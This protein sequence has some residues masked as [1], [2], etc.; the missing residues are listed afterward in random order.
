MAN[1]S[2]TISTKPPEQTA[3]NFA[4]LRE[5]GIAYIEKYAH[6]LWTDY[7]T[8]DPGIT[9]LEHLCYAITDLSLRTSL[10][11]SDL[12]T[13]S[14]GNEAAM[15]KSFLTAGKVLPTCPV[16]E[17]DYRKLFIDI[18]G[19]R[20][21]WL[22][23]AN[24]SVFVNCRE[25]DTARRLSY[26]APQPL[27]ANFLSFELKGLYTILVDYDQAYINQSIKDKGGDSLTQAQQETIQIQLHNS[28]KQQL[29]EAYEANRNLCEDIVD[30]TEVPI[31]YVMFCADIGLQNDA[32]VSD[33]YAQIL[34]Q[35]QQ[36]LTPL[37][38]RYSLPEMLA[39]TDTDKN[40]LTID[41]IFEGPLL[42]NGFIIDDELEAAALR[43]VV[44][45]SDLI[46]I[47]MGIEGV[48]DVKKVLLNTFEPAAPNTPCSQQIPKPNGE[49]RWC[50]HINHG[51]QPQLC[52]EN[53][54]LAF[55]KDIIP[56]GN[57]SD[58]T[59]ALAKFAELLAQAHSDNQ[60]QVD[61]L[62]VPVGTV[63]DLND[64]RSV[65]NDLPF[66]YGVGRFGLPASATNERKA[67][68]KQLKGYL[69]FFDQ[70]LANYLA[71][72]AN[73]KSLFSAEI[74]PAGPDL[75]ANP[76]FAQTYFGQVVT[77]MP[78]VKDLYDNYPDL[79]TTI[80]PDVLAE[81]EGYAENP[82]RKNRFLD[83]QLA[84]FAENFSDYA[85][86]MHSLFGERGNEEMLEDKASFLR[87][88]GQ[89]CRS[90][91]YNYCQ[92][93]WQTDN[94]AGIT[95]RLARLTGIRDTNYQAH[96]ASAVR[97]MSTFPSDEG[98]APQFKF[99]LHELQAST[100]RR[101]YLTSTHTYASQTEAEDAMQ[102][103]FL[104]VPSTDRFTIHAVQGGF[105]YVLKDKNNRTIARCPR[106]FPTYE[107][108]D[109]DVA[110]AIETLIY[111][112]EALF[113]VEHMLL[114]PNE[115]EQWMSVCVEP[116]C[117]HCE[118]LDP[119]SYR[120][121]V[122]LPGYTTRFRNV[123][124]RRYLENIIRS[125]LPAHVL[126]RICWVSQEQLADFEKKYK[127]WLKARA[128]ICTKPRTATYATAL[129]E[130]IDKLEDD[131]FHTI[132]EKG[133]LHDCDNED[134]ESPI[135]LNRTALGTLKPTEPDD[136]PNP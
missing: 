60:K 65:A 22:E 62:P 78:G 113:L 46:N 127:Q 111:S 16:S 38:K 55:Y 83:H 93:A 91:A 9:L 13:S 18:N 95:R 75:L 92:P 11:M 107:E 41:Q 74:T 88:Y 121:S 54:A 67:Q 15:Q 103:A 40:P 3:S 132:Y 52:A 19:V 118:P 49:Q 126:A 66:N 1:A 134:E 122:I 101:I 69:L 27:P 80:L 73:L 39:H 72:L 136:H 120:V 23:P 77:D 43:E 96:D 61:D 81:L 31:Q 108:A 7:N 32:K 87:E 50:L 109:A 104:T 51:H 48:K 84:R 98:T 71:Q 63:Y 36:Y 14:F 85:L 58:K 131:D 64:Y 34:F 24:Q 70:L 123:D 86:L 110:E 45:T 42:T 4:A 105:T 53:V 47:I 130:L 33:V 114:R 25:S 115:G 76:P 6:A 99:H 97:V 94:V 29:R 56:V 79:S 59:K 100:H 90:K 37:V 112:G 35:V 116:D 44:Y 20:N 128:G 8:H 125:E 117:E 12:L 119:Y 135:I 82:V 10:D 26:T 129:K 2:I 133:V 57:L 21:A 28:I 102:R 68:A 124:Y 30:V 5:L 106:T 89:I 17:L